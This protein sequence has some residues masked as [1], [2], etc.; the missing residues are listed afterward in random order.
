MK[1][2]ISLLLLLTSMVYSQDFELIGLPNSAP[3][4]GSDLFL[5]STAGGDL[6]KFT[7]TNLLGN[8]DD[9]TWAWTAGHTFG[10]TS[11]FNGNVDFNA[12]TSITSGTFYIQ[13][14]KT[15]STAGELANTS[16]HTYLKYRGAQEDTLATWRH[17]WQDGHSVYGVWNF[18]NAVTFSGSAILIGSGTSLTLNTVPAAVFSLGKVGNVG[19]GLVTFNYAASTADTLASWRHIWQ[20][21]ITTYGDRIHY[22]DWI[23]N[24][25]TTFNSSLLVGSG[26]ALSLN[27]THSSI[28]GAIGREGAAGSAF[29]TFNYDTSTPDTLLSWRQFLLGSNIIRGDWGFFGEATFGGETTFDEVTFNGVTDYNDNMSLNAMDIHVPQ[30]IGLT[31]GSQT[32]G[33][34]K[35]YLLLDGNGGEPTSAVS[36]FTGGDVDGNIILV[37]CDPSDV[38]GFIILNG[39]QIV[40]TLSRD[41]DMSAKDAVEFVYHDGSWY[42]LDP[43]EKE[44][45]YSEKYISGTPKVIS[46]AVT[47]NYY[48]IE[49]TG[50]GS[51]NNITD[52]NDSTFTIIN[53]GLYIIAYSL[54]FTHA[55]NSTLIHASLFVDDVEDTQTE[56]ERKVG[57]GGDMG[58]MSGTGLVSLT[59]GETVKVKVKSDKTGNLTIN[60]ANFNLVKTNN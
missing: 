13:N 29:V 36:D 42:E 15:A 11:A 57:T 40:T 31:T 10:G 26:V 53:T 6:Y 4:N 20:D 58:S 32:V 35:S 21:N 22:G 9:E 50:T 55:T 49:F 25:T 27:T 1:K 8:L 7:Y 44:G 46:T 60:H 39:V 17:I 52:T 48:G 30:T 18:I 2:I 56:A 33:F 38:D 54:S 47:G 59:A 37:Q 41:I 51:E 45:T 43:P 3:I 12:T 23:H 28:F 16:S 19:S 34:T 14:V 5:F 24:G